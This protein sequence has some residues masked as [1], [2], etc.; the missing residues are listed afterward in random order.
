MAAITHAD[1]LTRA[2]AVFNAGVG[3]S[4]KIIDPAATSDATANV[5]QVWDPQGGTATSAATARGNALDGWKSY[6]HADLGTAYS[7]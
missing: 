7:L 2:A 1:I 5:Y 6:S 4:V 3:A